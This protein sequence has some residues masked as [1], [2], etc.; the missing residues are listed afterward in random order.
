MLQ[1]VVDVLLYFSSDNLLLISRKTS[2][3]IGV[4]NL[5]QVSD[6]VTDDVNPAHSDDNQS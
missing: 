4:Q 2:F 3:L 6:K 5:S 1:N